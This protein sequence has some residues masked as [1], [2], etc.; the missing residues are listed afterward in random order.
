MSVCPPIHL[1]VIAVNVEPGVQGMGRL[2]NMC[3]CVS[4][5][6][7]VRLSATHLIVRADGPSVRLSC[8]LY[9]CPLVCYLFVCIGCLSNCPSCHLSL[10]VR[11]CPIQRRERPGVHSPCASIPR[12]RRSCSSR[13][14]SRW[15][16]AMP[17]TSSSSSGRRR[18][19][20]LRGRCGNGGTGFATV[21]PDARFARQG[22]ER[23][24]WFC[25]SG[26]SSRLC[27]HSS[28]EMDKT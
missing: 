16:T 2:G 1:S 19:R 27:S 4:V 17:A 5:H 3:V 6:S 21:A 9:V 22:R 10:S 7:P 28:G 14:A 12:F 18:T 11:Q 20:G 23:R 13:R 15:S 24:N 26:A 25:H 8:F